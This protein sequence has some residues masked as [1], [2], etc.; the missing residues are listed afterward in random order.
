MNGGKRMHVGFWWESYKERDR[1][2]DVD[3]GGTLVL[4]WIL[5][6]MG[7][8]GLASSGL[9][10]RPVE[11]SWEHSYEPVGFIKCWEILEYMS[12]WWLLR[13]DSVPWS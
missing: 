6:R 11:G 1:R 10:Y 3:V 12:D 8:Y 9:G 13:K 5:D 4:Q 7:W 2:E